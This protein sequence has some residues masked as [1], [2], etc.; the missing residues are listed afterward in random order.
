MSSILEKYTYEDLSNKSDTIVIGTVMETLPSRWNSIDG[1]KSDTID[2]FTLDNLIYTDIKISV[3]SY[4]KNPLSSKEIIV[5][6][7]GGKVG[8]DR[9]VS[10]DEPSFK[11]G[12][13]VLLYLHEDDNPATK[14][15]SPDHFVVTG[16]MQGKFTL[17]GDGKA[18]GCD[19]TISQDKLLST[20][21]K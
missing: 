19:E 14:D 3:D 8:K 2:E 13:R 21:E 9:F 10:E 5:R 11:S 6:V 20:I 16:Y 7:V 18:V 1:T 17:T 4:V 15:T 12:E